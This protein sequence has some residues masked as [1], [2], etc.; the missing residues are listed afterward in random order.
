MKIIAF[1]SMSASGKSE[2][3]QLAKDKDTGYPHG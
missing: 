2:A 1:I 3:V